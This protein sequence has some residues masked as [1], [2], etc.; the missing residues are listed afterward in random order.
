MSGDL[1]RR[2]CEG[3]IVGVTTN[4]AIFR[5][6]MRDSEQYEDQ[7]REYAHLG[8]GATEAV[9]SLM[10]SDVRRACDILR[11]VYE[12]T[13]GQDGRVS[14]EVDPNWAD[15]TPRTVAEARLLWWLVDRPNAMIKIPA[16]SAGLPAIRACLAEGISVN[17]TLIFSVE[18]YREVMAAFLDGMELARKNGHNLAEIASVASFFISRVDTEVDQ[19]LD[20]SDN[21]KARA[22]R[23]R[24]AIANATLAYQAYRQ[25]MSGPRWAGLVDAGAHPQRPL[26]ASTGVKDPAY[27]DTRYVVELVAPGTVNTMP[28][29]TLVAVAEHGVVRGDRMTANY[30]PARAVH[31]GLYELG[32]DM[33]EVARTLEQA[34]VAQFQDAW[35]ALIDDVS[36][37]LA[38]HRKI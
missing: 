6:S 36:T 25:T 37:M 35:K 31:D 27:D 9:R 14:I 34:G 4:P 21:P 22:L 23:G 11:P 17:A 8:M 28:E 16:T 29:A 12:S 24:A 13:A 3:Q 5:Q 33:A 19:R 15:D 26:W 10:C 38:R 7:L 1:V 30:V 18:R 2:V 20:G 32:I